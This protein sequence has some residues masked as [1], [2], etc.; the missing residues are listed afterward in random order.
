MGL[1]CSGDLGQIVGRIL[2]NDKNNQAMG[3]PRR[4]VE[5]LSLS[6]QKRDRNVLADVNMILLWD[7]G[8]IK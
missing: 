5:F 6:F 7:H 4:A 3:Y 1:N 8:E 2:C